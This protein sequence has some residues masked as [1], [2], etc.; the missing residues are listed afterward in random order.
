V[1]F[2]RDLKNLLTTGARHPGEGMTSEREESNVD[3]EAAAAS[4]MDI[5]GLAQSAGPSYPP[6]YVHE[7]DEGRPRK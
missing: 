3:A 7:Y 6:G 5:K 1:A 4:N 2:L